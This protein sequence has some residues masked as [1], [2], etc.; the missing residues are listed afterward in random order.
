MLGSS[1][2]LTGDVPWRRTFLRRTYTIAGLGII[3]SGVIAAGIYRLFG[4]KGPLVILEWVQKLPNNFREIALLAAGILIL[5]A[6]VGLGLVLLKWLENPSM[7][8]FVLFIAWIGFASLGGLLLSPVFYIAGFILTLKVFIITGVVFTGT[9]LL[10]SIIGIDLTRWGGQ[11]LSILIALTLMGA[12]NVFIQS[13]WIE[14]AWLYG[15]LVIWILVA[16][17]AHQLLA[18]LPMPTEEE[19]EQGALTRLAIGGALLL[20]VI[21]YA[22]FIRLLILAL[23]HQ[24]RRRR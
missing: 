9:G 21:F 17:Y 5:L 11:L 10:A 23:S 14:L 15:G 20:Y 13:E 2:T 24:G 7:P 18:K 19:V 3:L 8:L 1:A 22:L 16:V 6:M 4:S 12:V